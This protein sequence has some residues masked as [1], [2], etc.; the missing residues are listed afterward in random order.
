MVDELVKFFKN[1]YRKNSYSG[2][3]IWKI[4]KVQKNYFKRPLGAF[5]KELLAIY[6]FLKY[7]QFLNHAPEGITNTKFGNFRSIT[8]AENGWWVSEVL[9]KIQIEKVKFSGGKIWKY[10]KKNIDH[11]RPKEF[12]Q[13]SYE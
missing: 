2:A 3:K 7:G 1:A 9:Q 4:L 13:K 10:L 12:L 8:Y 11:K 5:I 6:V